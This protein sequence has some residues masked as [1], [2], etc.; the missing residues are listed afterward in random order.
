MDQAAPD[1]AYRPWKLLQRGDVAD[2]LAIFRD[3]YASRRGPGRTG[4]LGEAL[5]WIG[6][7]SA[8]AEHFRDAIA[9]DASHQGFNA[10][11]EEDFAFLGVAEWCLRDDAIAIKTWESGIKAIYSIGGSRTHCSL[12]LLL[13]AVLRPSLYR[14][15]RAEKVL[16][17]RLN[18]RTGTG[19]P[20]TVARYAAGLI[21]ATALE[22]SWPVTPPL[23]FRLLGPSA[24]WT[25]DFY[26]AM[27]DFAGGGITLDDARQAW[28]NLSEPSQYESGEVKDFY[29]IISIPEFFIARHEST[30]SSD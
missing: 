19:W 21:E 14:R 20:G 9:R 26:K 13:A 6:D 17:K 8:A 11:N 15:E 23:N 2:A 27:R 1:D 3:Q 22:I 25:R 16:F 7:Y 10:S 28:R 5:L 24:E 12:L 29:D 4:G 18:S 30:R